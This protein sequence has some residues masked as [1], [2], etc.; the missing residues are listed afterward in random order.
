MRPADSIYCLFKH[1]L[2]AVVFL[3]GFHGIGHAEDQPILGL[4][5]Q[6][7]NKD[8]ID[9][10][11]KLLEIEALLKK[12][13]SYRDCK[14]CPDSAVVYAIEALQIADSCF[15]INSETYID[16]FCDYMLDDVGLHKTTLVDAFFPFVT[17]A[18]DQKSKYVWKALYEMAFKMKNI[19]EFDKAI[20]LFERVIASVCPTG[21]KYA[22]QIN[23]AEIKYHFKEENPVPALTVLMNE[24]EKEK[25]P[26][27][28][29]LNF[30][31]AEVLADYYLDTA[32]YPQLIDIVEFG[33]KNA[34]YV[35]SHDLIMLLNKKKE[36]YLQTNHIKAIE[37][38]DRI[39]ELAD[40]SVVKTES[41]RHWLSVALIQRGDYCSSHNL[42]FSSSLDYYLRA[43]YISTD[44]LTTM[45]RVS[46]LAI[47]RLNSIV[48][49]SGSNDFI[50]NLGELLLAKFSDEL[51]ISESIE[52]IL[53]LVSAYIDAEK[54]SNAE[55]LL[56]KCEVLIEPNTKSAHRALIYHA[57]IE[58]KKNHYIDAINYLDSL[59]SLEPDKDIK[60][61]GLKYLKNAY[62]H[63]ADRR[64]EAISDSINIMTKDIISEEIK[65]ISPIQ[66]ANWIE[67]CD[68]SILCLL[69]DVENESSIKNALE[70]NL[71]KKNLLLRTSTSIKRN[72]IENHSLNY[73]K[74]LSSIHNDL[75]KAI[76]R[77][78]SLETIS[79]RREYDACEQC[80][81]SD[82]LG[83][84]SLLKDIDVTIDDVLHQLDDSD[85]A[86]DFI[87]F[88]ENQKYQLGAF[89]FSKKKS[90]QYIPLFSYYEETLPSNC[91]NHIWSKILP[92][93]EG[94]EDL[95][96][97]TDGSINSIPIEFAKVNGNKYIDDFIKLHRVFHLSEINSS[98]NVGEKICFVGVADHNASA[99]DIV[100][101]WRGNWTDL[102]NV[103]TE[104]EALSNH[105]SS[106]SLLILFNETATEQA[107]TALDESNISTL[108]ISTHGVF[109]NENALIE[110][111]K[112]S[113]S[114][115]YHIARRTLSANETSLSAIILHSGNKFWK[116]P[117][118]ENNMDDILMA[119]EIEMLHFPNLNLTVLSACE[120]GL[121]EIDS[122]GVWG[123][124]RAF[125]IAGTKNL[126][127]SL[128]KVDDYWTAQ[129]M[130]AFYEQAAKG[131]NIYD[132]FQS[133]Q[134]WLRRELPD[135]PEIWTSFIL[136]E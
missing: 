100:S 37:C 103:K 65:L 54:I 118:L 3:L 116:S 42:D 106:D 136:I 57:V 80:A 72:I 91:I 135:N 69:S 99:E 92:L 93:A 133:A 87:S 74:Q 10:G 125:R 6:I 102:P 58:I 21:Y 36:A 4:E 107:F 48:S 126:I 16:I 8:S 60:L 34:D 105:V 28:G 124:Q 30:M 49:D 94:Y 38:L 119:C 22:S 12:H 67:V 111:S 130:D 56:K 77:G 123:L 17:T 76:N 82:F 32:N 18:L 52:F 84:H 14:E 40:Q 64:V 112:Q 127:C 104:L 101:T 9:S 108:H 97:C 128:A 121:G 35:S 122:D 71:F 47:Q 68:E 110:A 115:D 41:D 25:Y 70:L 27:K 1:V 98:S 39:I 113:T 23:L 50:L 55:N 96:F 5:K 83:N 134:R 62:S 73:K 66:R 63:R 31:L 81:I 19:H 43:L 89:V 46:L 79:L 53:S 33:E 85:I 7:G 90:P 44:S 11:N 2:I 109:R 120:S 75:V 15:G 51:L 26:E 129:F 20:D 86:V 117:Y 13:D 29:E 61:R 45:D 78:D 59:M 114:D 95:Y 132:S 131:N 24:I 88:S